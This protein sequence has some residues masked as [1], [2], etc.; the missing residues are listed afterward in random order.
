MFDGEVVVLLVL[1]FQNCLKTE[2]IDKTDVMT[3]VLAQIKGLISMV[4]LN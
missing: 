4:L 3:L 1:M 2:I